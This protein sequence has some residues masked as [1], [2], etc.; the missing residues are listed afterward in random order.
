M[1]EG[2]NMN[3]KDRNEMILRGLRDLRVRFFD[4]AKQLYISTI[5]VKAEALPRWM[6]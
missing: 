6:K 5:C 4:L 3:H 1:P 2:W